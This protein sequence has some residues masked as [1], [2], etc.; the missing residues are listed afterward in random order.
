MGRPKH[1]K[2]A[3]PAPKA[4]AT[5]AKATPAPK[6]VAAKA[7]ATPAPKAVAAKAKATPVPTPSQPSPPVTRRRTAETKSNSSSQSTLSAYIK[8]GSVWSSPKCNL[9]ADLE[10]IMSRM[11]VDSQASTVPAEL[12]ASP[13]APTQPPCGRETLSDAD[14]AAADGTVATDGGA[15][16]DP[17]PPPTPQAP[18]EPITATAVK[19]KKRKRMPQQP[20]VSEILARPFSW[21]K[22]GADNPTERKLGADNPTV[23]TRKRK[24]VSETIPAET[25]P[26]DQPHTQ[27]VVDETLP[28]TAVGDTTA[29]DD[30][31]PC[32][33][34]GVPTTLQPATDGVREPDNLDCKGADCDVAASP[35]DQPHTQEVVNET[36][37][38]TAVGD[39]TIADVENPCPPS[40][41]PTT[42][43]P[44]T[45]GVRE[46]DTVDGNLDCK[47]ADCDVAAADQV[48]GHEPMLT[49]TTKPLSRHQRRLQ[50]KRVRVCLMQLHRYDIIDERQKAR[51]AAK[52]TKSKSDH[53]KT[54]LLGRSRRLRGKAPGFNRPSGS[55][56]T[57]RSKAHVYLNANKPQLLLDFLA[58]D[59]WARIPDDDRALIKEYVQFC[60]DNPNTK[61]WTIGTACSGSEVFMLGNKAL[62]R[63]FGL[64]EGSLFKQ[65]YGA[66]IDPDKRKFIKVTHPTLPA[67]FSSVATLSMTEGINTITSGGL[68]MQMTPVAQCFLLAA[69]FICKDISSLNPHA[70][71]ARGNVQSGSGRTGGTWKGLMSLCNSPHRPLNCIFENVVQLL[72]NDPSTGTTALDTCL[73]D[74]RGAG[75]S[76]VAMK[77]CPRRFGVPVRRARIYIIASLIL[78]LTELEAVCESIS[79][80]QV[81]T[82]CSLDNFM[83]RDNDPLVS[84][85][86]EACLAKKRVAAAKDASKAATAECEDAKWIT[87]HQVAFTT[88]GPR[89]NSDSKFAKAITQG[90]WVDLLTWREQTALGTKPSVDGVCDLSQ[91]EKREETVI[92]DG[93]PCVTPHSVLFHLGRERTCLPV[94]KCAM[95]GL[96]F[97]PE[98][99]DM[100]PDDVLADLAGNSFHVMITMCVLVSLLRVYARRLRELR[101]DP[102]T[103]ASGLDMT[104]VSD[105][106]TEMFDVS[107]SMGVDCDALMGEL[108]QD[109][110]IMS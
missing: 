30:E 23:A 25:V 14:R 107:E 47:G 75:Y 54:H 27:E 21:E 49:V 74:L 76:A 4:V 81:E 45:D 77:L 6:A 5:T 15:A 82:P 13:A 89:T 92:E 79:S 83:L 64:R 56:A 10:A 87:E 85:W 44:A 100:F 60:V 43:Q 16:A 55:S 99:L 26:D 42:L 38:D 106:M 103:G 58:N 18:T 102:D 35:D 86:F 12:P 3:T 52:S 72:A 8:P 108:S 19:S 68:K 78:T 22:G 31:N 9:E 109:E 7:E 70:K 90:R 65:L 33:P 39:T 2:T 59:L 51:R 29:A 69:G 62:E 48:D 88:E 36:L 95:Q 93:A 80:L 50:G 94:E 1:V 105:L 57:S 66:E 34:S 67:L 24:V 53:V 71:E 46:P 98:V 20:S 40:G 28:N 11:D 84:R 97:P 91:T 110:I 61:T 17:T 41:V 37:P 96:T 101:A 32:P 63:I 104:A 73:A